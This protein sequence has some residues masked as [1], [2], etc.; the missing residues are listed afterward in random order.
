MASN[1]QVSIILCRRAF[2]IALGIVIP[3]LLLTARTGFS[4]GNMELQS[5]AFNDG[6]KISTQ[7]ILK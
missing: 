7:Y 5:S 4:G 1:F 2:I 6:G 3:F